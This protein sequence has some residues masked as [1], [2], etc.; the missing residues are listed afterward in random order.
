VFLKADM[1]H[2]QS[3][4][5]LGIFASGMKADRQIAHSTRLCNTNMNICSPFRLHAWLWRYL[6]FIVEKIKPGKNGEQNLK[7]ANPGKNEEQIFKNACRVLLLIFTWSNN[8][9]QGPKDISM[10]RAR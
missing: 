8:E 4:N 10:C 2:S 1:I 5:T 3:D 9:F 7:N 6:T